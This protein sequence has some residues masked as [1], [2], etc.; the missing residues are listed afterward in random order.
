[1][2]TVILGTW[3]PHAKMISSAN[4]RH[5]TIRAGQNARNVLIVQAIEGWAALPGNGQA[6]PP[7]QMQ[8]FG[9]L[10]HL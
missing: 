4:N 10:R 3:Q 5:T 1:M 9:G 7:V 8:P 6:E 2:T